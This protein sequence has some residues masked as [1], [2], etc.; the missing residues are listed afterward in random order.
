MNAKKRILLID[1]DPNFRAMA[2]GIL[3]EKDIEVISAAS[4]RE[5]KIELM[6]GHFDLM[7]VDG[8]LPDMDGLSFIEEQRKNER[9]SSIK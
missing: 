8:I 2:S 6:Q 4:A 5:A 9:H 7:I 3:K 1:D